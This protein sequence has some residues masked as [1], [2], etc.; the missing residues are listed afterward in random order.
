MTVDI[1]TVMWKEFKEILHLRG[2][3][4]GSLFVMIVPA[5]LFGVIF[6]LQFGSQWTET[7]FSIIVW[8]VVPFILISTVIADSFAGERERNTLETLLASRLTEKS[9]LLGKI[10]A[11]IIYAMA[12]T[13]IIIILGLITVNLSNSEGGILLFSPKVFIAGLIAGFFTSSIAVNVGTL[14]SL[15]AATVRQAQQ[16]LGIA[17]F[18]LFFSPSII[19]QF[20]PKSYLDSIETFFRAFELNVIIAAIL[21]ILLAV[22]IFLFLWTLARFKRNRMIFD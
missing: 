14:V 4:I 1:L 20:V 16:T 5:F 11:A 6:P 12:I 8:M 2:S 18:V 3:K 10:F 15:R 17:M 19:A 22:D 13:L 7:P 21:C 9:I